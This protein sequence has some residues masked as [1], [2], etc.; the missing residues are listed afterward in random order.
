MSDRINRREFAGLVA[1]GVTAL[2]GVAPAWAQPSGA[3]AVRQTVDTMRFAE[4]PALKWQPAEGSSNEAIVLKPG[5]GGFSA[6]QL[7][8]QPE[9]DVTLCEPCAA[10]GNSRVSKER[11]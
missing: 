8:H 7:H 5:G 11:E 10:A 3:I 9:L 6:G 2:A 4:E 1:G